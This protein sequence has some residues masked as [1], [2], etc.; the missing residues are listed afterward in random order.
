MKL[1]TL[2]AGALLVILA[3]SSLFGCTKD[4]EE[5]PESTVSSLD[6]ALDSGVTDK[7]VDEETARRQAA[8]LEEKEKAAL[9]TQRLQKAYGLLNL[10]ED[11]RES[12]FHG[13]KNVEHQSYLV[14]HDTEGSGSPQSVVDYWEGSG[15]GVAAHFI[16]GKDGS[17][18]Q[19]VPLEAIAHH[20]GFGDTGH[21]ELYNVPDE[22][23]DD[24]IGT[25]SIGDWAADYGMNSYSI[26]IELVHVGG[27]GEYPTAQLQALDEL[28][29]YLD[30]FYVD[31][32]SGNAGMI[33]DHKAWRT[34]NSDT[35]P[36]F[37]G[38]LA[39]YQQHRKHQGSV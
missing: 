12:F 21:N 27:E 9:L 39:S 4:I 19:C 23:R 34:G 28:I 2:A 17:I 36:E 20:S 13:V 33:I 11:Y 26:G 3:S 15:A 8:E 16:V 22:S 1:N 31:A 5:V 30:L 38:H 24:K 14:L 7:M 10:T 18:V 29:A 35:S 37:A 32:P 6:A 25:A